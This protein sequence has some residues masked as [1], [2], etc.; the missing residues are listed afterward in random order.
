MA[1][2]TFPPIME[3]RLDIS[4]IVSKDDFATQL[5]SLKKMLDESESPEPSLVMLA[6]YMSLT[7]GDSTAA[8]EYA[9]ALSRIASDDKLMSTYAEFVLTGERPEADDE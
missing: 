9:T 1:M 2:L 3:T 5:A 4:Q 8:K 7:N 6:T